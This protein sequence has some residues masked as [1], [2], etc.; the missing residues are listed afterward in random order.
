MTAKESLIKSME[1]WVENDRRITWPDQMED[2]GDLIDLENEITFII[3]DYEFNMAE[4][5]YMIEIMFADQ[6]QLIAQ[7]RKTA[8]NMEDLSQEVNDFIYYSIP[9]ML[10]RHFADTVYGTKQY[11]RAS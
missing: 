8:F 4:T 2:I 1:E 7:E 9:D 3:D 6:K 5:L 11:L 10:A